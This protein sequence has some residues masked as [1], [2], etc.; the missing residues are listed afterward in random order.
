M[1]FKLR[2]SFWC[3]VFGGRFVVLLFSCVLFFVARL[4]GFRVSVSFFSFTLSHPAPFFP[5][6]QTP[7]CTCSRKKSRTE[8]KPNL[9]CEFNSFSYRSKINRRLP[10]LPFYYSLLVIST[11]TILFISYLIILWFFFSFLHGC[12]KNKTSCKEF[13]YY[14]FLLTAAAEYDTEEK[15]TAINIKH[16]Y[17]F[18]F[19]SFSFTIFQGLYK[20]TGSK[21]IICEEIIYLC[22]CYDVNLELYL[23]VDFS[24]NF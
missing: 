19:C 14:L 9:K 10:F 13:V 4:L 21:R 15:I 23:I 17:V 3:R 20:P 7:K 12:P 16:K 6:P 2:V 8:K 24:I 18:Q 1:K 11:H 22:F 5:I